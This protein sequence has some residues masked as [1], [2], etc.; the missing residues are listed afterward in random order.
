MSVFSKLPAV[1]VLSL[2]M[3]CASTLMAPQSPTHAQEMVERI[4]AVVNDEV[5]TSSAVLSRLRLALFASGL[6]PTQENQQRLLPQVLRTLIDERLRQQEAN[7][8][9]LLVADDEVDAAV[10]S[11]A[12]D[13]GMEPAQ[14]TGLLQRNNVPVA[15]LRTQVATSLAWRQLI[16][17]RL[18][19]S[20]TIGEDEIDSVMRRIEANRGLP[21]Y[22]LAEIFLAV[23]TPQREAEVR[24]FAEELVQDIRR[25]ANF[26]AVARQ[27]S[28]GAGAVNGGDLGWV[29]Q[30]QLA[31]ELEQAAATLAT[32]QMS[33]PVRTVSGYHILL[34]R[35]Q[36]RA[37]V[38]DALDA[39]IQMA[40]LGV[41]FPSDANQQEVAQIVA[42]MNQVSETV[43][44]CPALE[45]RAQELGAPSTDGGS[46]RLRDLPPQ[47]AS[48][49][50]NQPVGEPTD[51][52]RMADGIAVFMVCDRQEGNTASRDEI[53]DQIRMERLDMLQ[54]RLLR[55]LRSAAFIDV[56]L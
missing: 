36:R 20:V 49:L 8:L 27:F 26:A 37:N 55:D 21:E 47:L 40:R 2:T 12:R 35:Q 43:A 6:T 13:N 5:I 15:T 32:G 14:F 44:G 52:V 25:G 29:I 11:I 7:R 51:P 46:G 33:D 1:A 28:Q 54:R 38:P 4:A 16:Q 41:P 9:N 23:D 31:P 34:L 18:L 45:E 22:L 53:A 10:A 48:L 39:V 50:Q 42:S 24:D 17:R 56:R 3:V 19:P 30:G